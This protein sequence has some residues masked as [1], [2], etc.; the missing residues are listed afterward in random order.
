[1]NILNTYFDKI[2][3][4]NLD[5]RTDRWKE[6]EELLKLYD[7]TNYERVSAIRPFYKEIPKDYYNNLFVL[8]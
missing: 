8:L 4:I 6:C 7:I 3:I 5:S 2:F 1:M